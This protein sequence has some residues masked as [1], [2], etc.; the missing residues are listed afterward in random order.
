VTSRERVRLALSHREP[1]RVPI[2]YYSTPEAQ[3]ELKRYLGITSD[4]ELM[5]RVG[6]DYRWLFP[7]F[8]GPAHMHW[9]FG[10]DKPGM[11]AW[12]VVRKEV[13]NDYGSY[14]EIVDYPLAH[15][16]TAEQIEEYPWPRLEWFDFDSIARQIAK[17][18]EDGEYWLC[19]TFSGSVFEYSWYMRGLERF[20]MDMV[21]QPDIA[22]KIMEKVY[23]FWTSITEETIRASKGR[24]DMVRLGD[25]VGGQHGMVISPSLWRSMIKPWFEKYFGMYKSLGVK[26]FY[27]SCGGIGPIIKDLAE[28]GLDVLNPLQFSSSA[29]PSERELKSLYGAQLSFE[30]GVD[31]QSTLPFGTVEQVSARTLELIQILGQGGGF[32][33]E[34]SH[35]IQPDTSPQ[36]VMAMYDTALAHSYR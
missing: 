30:G 4:R 23:G 22:N 34:P 8:V 6:C 21:L 36:N 25:D 32:I 14:I 24:I 27:H 15:V 33:L 16:T 31:T 1:D 2:G 11:D 28:I 35:A 17:S 18:Q 26:T 7:D 5:K 29:F 19:M 13:H 20:L 9:D 3:R 10:I 12:G